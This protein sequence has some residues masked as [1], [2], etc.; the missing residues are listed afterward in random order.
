MFHIKRLY[1]FILEAF[2]PIFSMTFGICLFIVLMQF[3]WKYVEDMVG[4]GLDTVVLGELFFYSALYLIPM[5]LPLAILLGS[6]MTFGNMGERLELLAIKASGVSL[7]K[8]MSPLIILV[9]II[10]IGAFFFQNEAMPRI[11]VKQKTLLTSI[12]QKSPELDIPEGSFYNGI[13]NY[14]IYVKKKN[15]ETRILYDVMIYNTSEGFND[16]MVFVCD[17]AKMSV[18]ET[19]DFLLLNLY[20]GQRF[21]SFREA[22]INSNNTYKS[23]SNQF[24]PYS[25]ENFKQKDIIIKF[26]TNFNRL[27]ESSMEGSG[28]AM[29]LSKLHFSRDSVQNLLDSM[30]IVDR[31]TMKHS[32]LRHFIAQD[33]AST[34]ATKPHKEIAKLDFDSLLNSLPRTTTLS[35]F[36]RASSGE[37][38]NASTFLIQS[39]T[40]N[41]YQQQVRHYKLL[42]HQKFTL[43]FACL[44]FFFIGAPL[45]AIIRKGGLGMP[46][47]IS[48]ILFIIYYILDTMGIKMARDGIWLIPIG[49]WFSSMILF[50]LGVFLTYKAMNDSAL[51]NVEAYNKYFYKIL[52]IK[53]AL[54]VSIE[55]KSHILQQIPTVAQLGAD[56]DLVERMNKMDIDKLKEAVLTKATDEQEQKARLLAL[57]ILK[58]KG[59][60]LDQMI[61]QQDIS[62]KESK[63]GLFNSSALWTGITYII[64]LICIIIGQKTKADTLVYIAGIAYFVMFLRTLTYYTNFYNASHPK[65][66]KSYHTIVVVLAFFLFPIMYFFIKKQMEKDINRTEPII[67][68]E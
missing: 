4:K 68:S 12:K 19:K 38:N 5:A 41:T 13:E 15:K 52:R 42:A 2:V 40:K 46:V 32:Y 31:K 23:R 64:A 39:Y 65:K 22:D 3:L 58:D 1:R 49:M 26:D 36:E 10:S 67:V 63:A 54:K 60:S 44:I 48:V 66:K 24:V 34:Q 11:A 35:V 25:R 53:P 30:N 17:S 43:S 47:I 18:A 8:A 14:S 59:A 33:T 61:E 7:L 50:P 6:L 62:V 21:S 37:E 27:D 9:S 28:I 29:N 45:G 56:P 55:E 20:S 51:F 16:M 57:A